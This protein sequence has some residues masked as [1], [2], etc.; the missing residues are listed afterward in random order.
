M[1]G[2][3]LQSSYA[4]GN[5][6]YLDGKPIPG[7]TSPSIEA[8][9]S[10]V[11]KVVVTSSNCTTSV[12]RVVVITGLEPALPA[13]ITIYPNPTTDLLTVAVKSSNEVNARLVNVMGA[14]V[15]DQPLDGTSVKKGSFN[16]QEQ[17]EG[18]YILIVQDGDKVYKTRIIKKRW[19]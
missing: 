14:T 16:M 7:A 9:Q 11:Y 8:N 19:E 5:Q 10:G 4:E 13:H 6:W 15:Y 12:E 1:G 17:S 18:M 3:V 2:K